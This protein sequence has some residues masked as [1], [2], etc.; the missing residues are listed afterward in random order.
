M[1]FGNY[2]F[3]KLNNIRDLGGLP[4]ENGKIIKYGKLIRSAKPYRLPKKTIKELKAYGLT[5]M[6]DVRTPK[7]CEEKPCTRIEGVKY[8]NIPLVGTATPVITHEKSSI[9]NF[10]SESKRIKTEFGNAENYVKR[11]YEII[12]FD[13][14]SRGRIRKFFELLLEED[15]CVLWFCNQGKDRTGILAMLTEW[16]LGVDEADVVNDFV[17]SAFFMRKRRKLQKI[18][19]HI[20][21]GPRGLKLMLLA[22]LNVKPQYITGAMD[23]IKQK[24]GGIDRYFTQALGIT[25]EQILMLKDKYLE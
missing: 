9:K 7:E 12:L 17:A 15:G 18:G 4:A 14:A 8:I 20:T 16:V 5:A 13:E 22:I 6:V 10:I 23:A 2:K 21:P 1:S 11:M 25:E 19:V 24:Y 3:K